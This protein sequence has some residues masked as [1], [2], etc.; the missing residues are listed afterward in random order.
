MALTTDSR[1]ES[2]PRVID[3]PIISADSVVV[4]S[5]GLLPPPPHAAAN[6]SEASKDERVR[7]AI[8]TCGVPKRSMA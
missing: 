4:V 3:S 5:A 7:M 6:R 1:I 8:Q 2:A